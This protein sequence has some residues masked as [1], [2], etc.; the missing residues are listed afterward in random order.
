MEQDGARLATSSLYSVYAEWA[1]GNG[2]KPLN[3][4]NFVGE[5][6]RRYEVRHTESGNAVIG[7]A[8][9][10]PQPPPHENVMAA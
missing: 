8:L 10:F 5:L 3:S 9:F 1:K 7:L 2:Y 4:R 6:R